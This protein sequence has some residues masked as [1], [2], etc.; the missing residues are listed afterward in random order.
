MGPLASPS[1]GLP[2]SVGLVALLAPPSAGLLV[3]PSV[4]SLAP[5]SLG[6]L[7]PLAPPSLGLLFPLAPPSL[8]LLFPLAL[9]LLQLQPSFLTSIFLQPPQVYLSFFPSLHPPQLYLSFFPS[10]L[11]S[12][13]QSS[14]S[15][16]PSFVC[17]LRALAF[18][19]HRPHRQ[20][21][22]SLFV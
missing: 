10:L 5:P 16:L 9:L 21:C 20:G 1:A 19:W 6:L 15:S 17:L 2:L 12:S 18:P 22:D 13:F 11:S 3:S 7:F 8:G 4:R 14:Q